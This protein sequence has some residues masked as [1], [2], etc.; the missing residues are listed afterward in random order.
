MSGHGVIAV[1]LYRLIV[2]G[3]V[4]TWT[5][6]MTMSGAMAISIYLLSNT[7]IRSDPFA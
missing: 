6:L 4:L 2:V 3:D 5:T 1:E 7:V